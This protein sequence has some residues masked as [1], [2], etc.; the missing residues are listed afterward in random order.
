MLQRKFRMESADIVLIFPLMLNAID[1][2]DRQVL[3]KNINHLNKV[4]DIEAEV[5]VY[6]WNKDTF[7]NDLMHKDEKAIDF[8]MF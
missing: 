8:C 7:V 1:T 6:G 2:Q 5:D 4:I 3:L